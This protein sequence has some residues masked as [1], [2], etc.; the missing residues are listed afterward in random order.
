MAKINKTIKNQSTSKKKIS[1]FSSPDFLYFAGT[2]LIVFFIYSFSLFRPWLPFD[3]RLLSQETFFPIPTRFDEIF[4]VINT[5]ILKSHVISGNT[6]FS[7]IATLR[8]N[9]ITFAFIVFIS[10]FFQK[11][12]FFYH[13]LQLFIHLINTT[14]VYLILKKSLSILTYNQK[15]TNHTFSIPIISLF[16]VLWGLHS[17]NTEAVLLVTNLTAILTYTF[18][19]CF[20][21]YEISKIEKTILYISKGETSLISLLFFILMFLTEYGYSLPLILFFIVFAYGIRNTLSIKDS[22][23]SAC[24]AT[25]PYFLGLLLFVLISLLKPTSVINNL[26][27]S[28]NTIYSIYKTSFIS[29][30]IERNLWLVPQLFVHFVKLLFFPKTLSLFQSNL[31]HLSHTLISAYSIFSFLSYLL[32]ITIPAI[33]FLLFRKKNHGFIYPLIYAFYFSIFPFLHIITPTYCLSADRYCYFPSFI[34]V[35]ILIQI[36]NL[37]LYGKSQQTLKFAL[38]GISFIVLAL[39]C[40]TLIRFQ[41]WNDNDRLYTSAA[42]VEK[43]PLYKAQRLV[44]LANSVGERGNQALMEKYLNDSLKLLNKALKQYNYKKGDSIKEPITLKLY[45]LDNKSLSLQSAYSIAAIKNSNYREAPKKILEFLDPYF[46]NNL[47]ILGITPIVLY[48]E[49]LLGAGQLDQVRKVLEYGFKKYDFSDDISNKLAEYYMFYEKDYDKSFKVLQHAYAY[50]PNNPQILEKLLKYYEYK[51][52]LSNQAKIAY[53]IGL[54]LHYPE[55]YQRAVQTYLDLNQLQ[56]ANKALRKLIRLKSDDPLTYLLTSRYLD[57]TGQRSKILGVLN[58]ALILSNKLGDKQ[59][60]NV[61]KSILV[62]LINVNASLGNINNAKQF[63]S[64]FEKF[65]DLT[66]QDKLQ[67][68]TSK[69]FLDKTEDKHALKSVSRQ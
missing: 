5:F 36:L 23:T 69:K 30:F 53:L 1:F 12:A 18:C 68:Q 65:K 60:I 25:L 40:R 62:S 21:L 29:A 61:T 28:Q 57:M 48:S 38:I 4:E 16:T 58:S 39:S 11:N 66:P 26:F 6:F 55:S 44:I 47:K 9:P 33:L 20:I 37:M 2:V 50:F 17:A 43:N 32:F 15:D 19:F 34:I 63:L 45:G 8:S 49:I 35:F 46:K 22:L 42:R 14:L 54:R 10:F 24:K 56:L 64:V 3:E 7:N 41:D 51:N 31:V 59:D 52:D 67:I 13:C 27:S